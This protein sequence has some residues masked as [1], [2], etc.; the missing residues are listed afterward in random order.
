M[1]P[2]FQKSMGADKSSLDTVFNAIATASDDYVV[3]F[4]EVLTHVSRAE[5]WIQDALIAYAC[6]YSGSDSAFTCAETPDPL[7]DYDAFC[8][9]VKRRRRF[10]N[11]TKALAMLGF[12]RILASRSHDALRVICDPT[13]QAKELAIAYVAD[14]ISSAHDVP[15]IVS[16]LRQVVADPRAYGVDARSKFALMAAIPSLCT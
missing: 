8:R 7:A 1:L 10:R 15:A 5:E 2:H 16:K 14:T 4:V 6:T 13:D 12:G 3:V 9:S 11:I